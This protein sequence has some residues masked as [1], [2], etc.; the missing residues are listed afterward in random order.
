MA[1]V[2]FDEFSSNFEFIRVLR[3]PIVA[4]FKH[5]PQKTPKYL[6]GGDVP[7]APIGAQV[8]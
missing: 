5:R 2:Y 3:C 6:A 1:V 4:R 8:I 7:I